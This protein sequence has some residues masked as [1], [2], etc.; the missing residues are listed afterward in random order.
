MD[1]VVSIHRLASQNWVT[2]EVHADAA[3]CIKLVCG[4]G[5]LSTSNKASMVVAGHAAYRQDQL[6]QPVEG[7]EQCCSSAW[8]GL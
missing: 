2:A 5:I 8:R 7:K 6:W 4:A 1:L 3:G